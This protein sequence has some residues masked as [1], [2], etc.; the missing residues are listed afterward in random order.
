MSRADAGEPFLEEPWR[1]RHSDIV[2]DR[3]GVAVEAGRPASRSPSERRCET[4]AV[5][6]PASPANFV[7]SAREGLT[8]EMLRREPLG[9][10]LFA[11]DPDVAGRPTNR[12]AG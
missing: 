6:A 12:F 7:P 9:G 10:S 8:S 11:C 5:R 1:V 2:A 3:S 4:T